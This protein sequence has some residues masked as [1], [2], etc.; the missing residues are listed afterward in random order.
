MNAK[1]T[2]GRDGRAG[3]AVVIGAGSGIGRA[4]TRELLR[5]G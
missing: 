3:I 1:E 5:G 2:D 4:V